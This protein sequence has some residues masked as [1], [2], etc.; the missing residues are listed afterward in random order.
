MVIYSILKSNFYRGC[1]SF[2]WKQNICSRKKQRSIFCLWKRNFVLENV[3]LDEFGYLEKQGCLLKLTIFFGNLPIFKTYRFQRW[4]VWWSLETNFVYYKRIQLT[5]QSY[6]DVFSFC[7]FLNQF[8]SFHFISELILHI[9]G[10]I[11][12]KTKDYDIIIK[13]ST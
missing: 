11:I 13:L 8:P 1:I 12:S 4:Y 6:T 9:N 5:Q 7:C 10:Y 2:L 3:V